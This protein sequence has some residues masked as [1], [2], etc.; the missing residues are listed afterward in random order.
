MAAPPRQHGVAALAAT[1]LPLL[2]AF[3]LRAARLEYQSLWYDEGSS[4]FLSRQ[5]LPAITAGTANDIH[6]PLYYYL[7][8]FWM[9]AAGRTEFAVRGLSLL[10]GVLVVALVLALGRR[11]FDVRTGLLAAGAAAVSPLLVYYSQETRMYMQVTLFGLLAT[12]LLARATASP[13]P[14]RGQAAWL[15]AAYAVA[16]LACVYSQYVG[17]FVLLVHGLYVLSCRRRHLLWIAGAGVVIVLAYLPWLRLAGHA[18][19]IWPSTSAFAAGPRVFSDTAFRFTE[20][21]SAAISPLTVALTLLTVALAASGLS[22]RGR[23]S[24]AD[25]AKVLL[26]L[27][28]AVPIVA[29]FLLGYRKPLYNPKFALVAIPGFA[30]L[31]GAGLARLRKL[32]AIGAAVLLTASGIALA[33]YYFNPAFARDNYR[34]VAAYISASQRPGDAILLNAPGQE[35]IFPYYYRGP[36]PVIPLPAERPLVPAQTSTELAQLNARYKRLWLVL[37]GTNGSDPTNY[38]ENWLASKDYEIQNTWYGN[39]RLVAFSVPRAGPPPNRPT[40]ATIGGFAHLAAYGF[41]P[42][43]VT[44]GN[45]VQLGLRWQAAAATRSR[46]KVFTH[47]VDAQGNIWAQRDSEPVGGARPTTTWRAG[48]TIADNYGLLV[49]PGTPPGQYAI[50][51][52][53]YGASSGQRLSITAGG[54]GDRLLLP[55]LRIVAPAQPPSVAELSIPHALARPL[56]AEELLGYGL[57]LVGQDAE[58]THFAPGDL[59][60]LTLFWQ[61]QRA[62]ASNAT[63]AIAL[64][65]GSRQITLARGTLL[66]QHPTSAWQA[67]DRYREQKRLALPPGWS[68]SADLTISLHG[69]LP[70]RITRISLG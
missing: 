60:H 47:V 12:Y 31:L 8:H 39:V 49:L 34:G 66:A 11:L 14:G 6:P 64:R 19:L 38:V 29:M 23:G 52:G 20:G 48:D 44:S 69:G 43:P 18:L 5:S 27:Y 30:L 62:T 7:L 13:M 33:G 46:E 35:Q 67:G 42:N 17:A 63:I 61:S 37:Y 36:L 45:V 41:T 21:L 10:Q 55:G 70:V 3:G 24:M 65:Q 54:S 25:G 56:G 4:L 59:L 50:E 16:A 51:L 40:N 9:L 2:V 58:A 28:V 53:M 32:G 57:T 1:G 22:L 26:G 15:W 68:G